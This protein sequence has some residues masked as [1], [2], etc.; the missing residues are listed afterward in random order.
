MNSGIGRYI[1]SVLHPENYHGNGKT[2][3]FFEGWYFKLVDADETFRYCIIPGVYLSKNPADTHAF[4]QFMDGVS[5]ESIYQPYPYSD[6]NFSEKGF[7]VQIGENR[8]SS[9]TIHVDID[10]PD[11]KVMGDLNFE[12][13]TPWPVSLR[14]PGIMGWYGWVPG[15]E[16]YHGVVS[17][18]HTIQGRLQINANQIDFSGGAG[19]IEKDWGKSF[20]K[21]WI[22]MQT[23]HFSQ[24]NT[25]LTASAAVIPW[26]GRTFNGFIAGLWTGNQ[27]HRFATYTGAHLDDTSVTD[28]EAH[29][30]FTGRS[31]RLELT[32]ERA[33]GGIL[34]APTTAQMNRR[35]TESLS[36]QVHVTLFKKNGNA[37]IKTFEDTGR[38]AGLEVMGNLEG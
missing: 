7:E 28:H 12:G 13:L 18:N 1:Y 25:C 9:H 15:M 35:I 30:V 37:W 26:Q 21:A 33:E 5:G 32:A 3:P 17:L 34:Q 23:N 22:W 11:L 36:A 24:P 10:H 8:F 14:S 27:L 31:E 20:P 19:Y 6:F 4:I 29:L 16:C 2:G 38:Y